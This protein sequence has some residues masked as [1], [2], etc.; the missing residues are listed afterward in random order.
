MGRSRTP[1]KGTGSTRLASH[2]AIPNYLDALVDE[3]MIWKGVWPVPKF[4]TRKLP[5]GPGGKGKFG[6]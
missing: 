2:L 3:A 5:P 1:L 4:P 6:A